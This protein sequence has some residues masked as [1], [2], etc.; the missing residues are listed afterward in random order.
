MKN[1]EAY[2]LTKQ[3]LEYL[4]YIN[5]DIDNLVVIN[6]RYDEYEELSSFRPNGTYAHGD[7]EE[8]LGHDIYNFKL[9]RDIIGFNFGFDKVPPSVM[10]EGFYDCKTECGKECILY[11]WNSKKE[12]GDKIYRR[13]LVVL[14]DDPKSG[15]FALES[16]NNKN[17][18]L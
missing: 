8:L 15:M 4:D 3:Q 14:K 11:L 16:F 17:D 10:P 2:N 13:G 6:P 9:K 12:I 5:L 18:Y 7:L 1:S